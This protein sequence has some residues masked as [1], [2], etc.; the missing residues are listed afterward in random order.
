MET[1]D[2]TSNGDN[3]EWAGSDR[4]L[5]S[6]DVDNWGRI[7]GGNDVAEDGE[8][9]RGLKDEAVNNGVMIE[10]GNGIVEG[11]EVWGLKEAVNN[12]VAIEV[13]NGVAEGEEVRGLK[14]EAVNNG[15]TLEG[16]NGVAESKEVWGLKNETVN[17][18]LAVEGGN[19][20]AEGEEVQDL[21]NETV[22]NMAI[23]GGN[24]VAEG[25]EVWV[26]KNEVINSG[27]AIADGNGVAEDGEVS[28]SNTEAANVGVAISDGNG[29]AEGGEVWGSK[30][31]AVNNEVVIADGNVV[32]YSGEVQ[33]SKNEAV[34]NEMVIADG[35][36][37]TEGEEV[38]CLK[39]GTVDNVVAIA[40]G[41]GVVEGYSG[42]IECFRTY[43]RRKHV[44]SSSEF[45]VQEDSKQ[46]MEAASHLS[47][48]AVKRPCDLP[49]G[50]TSKDYSR[51]NWGNIVLK[52][53]YHSLGND[54]GSMEWC[55]REALMSRPKISCATTMTVGPAET[56]KID[57]DG[58]E[59]SLQLECL[60]YRLQSEANGH[61]NV[62]H[63]GFSG[64]SD[65]RGATESCQCVFRD[66]LAS[67]KFSSLCK[68][69]LENFQGM[70]PDS[71]FDFSVV[72]SRMKGRAYE[73]SPTLFLSDVQQVWQKLQNTGN[74]IVAIAKSLSNMSKASFYEQVGISVQ[75][76]F[77]DEKQVEFISHMKPEQTVECVTYKVGSCRHCGD[78]AD[79][80]DCLVCDSCEEMY[81]LS[82]IEPAV[83]E[84]PRK[85]W[86]CA[87]CTASGIGCRHEN[88]VVCERLNVPKT[89][90]DVVGEKSIPTNEE[91]LNELKRTQIV[92]MMGFKF[93]QVGESHLTA[94]F[95]KW[96]WMVKK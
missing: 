70:K 24:G 59:S 11:E 73:Q 82:C 92:L 89:L 27:V 49:V 67:E 94:K 25:E 47:D 12:E 63:N 7:Q 29:V 58:Q 23:E 66:I 78:K 8:E 41:F 72:N 74:Q 65:G 44:K 13:G 3:G 1:E 34:N 84:I 6:E 53:L 51:D 2:G 10:G 5:D 22:N 79:G 56:L 88:C 81:H 46:P 45:K 96:W 35:N 43:K 36:G 31:E 30:N 62:M 75:S 95:V 20:V 87:N 77:E 76:S 4:R 14:H 15:V 90:D 40:D 54:N 21:K 28:G 86:F 38:H 17:T 71:V 68:V 42:A 9:D 55:I 61:A 52:H 32:A 60:F 85:S 33:D 57:K 39:N 64:E 48:Q 50:N 93:P 83:K 26:L 18:G 69:L 37:V 16:G 91:T 19:G 80:T